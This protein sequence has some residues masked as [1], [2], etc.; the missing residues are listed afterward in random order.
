M[1]LN[2]N[3]FETIKIKQEGKYPFVNDLLNALSETDNDLIVF[4][5][6]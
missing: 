4:I 5:N 1:D 2:F 3:D 6:N